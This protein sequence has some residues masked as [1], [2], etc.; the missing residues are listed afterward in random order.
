M[1]VLRDGLRDELA[2]VLG[3]PAADVDDTATFE[4][5]GIDSVFGVMFIQSV[6]RRY[7]LKEPLDLTERCRDLDELDRYLATRIPEASR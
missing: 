2:K 7:G 5:L 4:D 3:C 6:N 1:I